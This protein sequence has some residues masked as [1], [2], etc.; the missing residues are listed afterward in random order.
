L[1]KPS[2]TQMY[3]PGISR[4]SRYPCV[5]ATDSAHLITSVCET[6]A[7]L[8]GK[9]SYTTYISE[10]FCQSKKIRFSINTPEPQIKQKNTRSSDKKQQWRHCI[11]LQLTN[12]QPGL[13]MCR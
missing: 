13:K 9:Y 5:L 12:F 8:N 1:V 11:R 7:F 3:W 2:P 4:N 10:I 6:T